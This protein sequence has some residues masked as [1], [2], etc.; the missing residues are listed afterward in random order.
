MEASVRSAA[1]KLI[2][3]RRCGQYDA[4]TPIR[5]DRRTD[6]ARSFGRAGESCLATVRKYLNLQHA[7]TWYAALHGAC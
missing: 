2:L 6:H 3:R 7:L 5:F 1:Q 4:G